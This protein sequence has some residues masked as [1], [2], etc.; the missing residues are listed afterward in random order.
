MMLAESYRQRGPSLTQTSR[1]MP[2]VLLSG[3]TEDRRL[4]RRGQVH[5]GRNADLPAEHYGWRVMFSFFLL[6]KIF[7]HMPMNAQTSKI[8]NTRQDLNRKWT[9]RLNM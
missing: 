3:R 7:T 2:Q 5:G 6:Q 9:W 8:Q 4:G 1:Q